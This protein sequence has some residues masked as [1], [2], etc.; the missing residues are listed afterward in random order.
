MYLLIK[1]L[2][3]LEPPCNP[4]IDCSNQGTCNDDKTCTCNDGFSGDDCSSKY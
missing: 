1:Y 2:V 4:E 3:F